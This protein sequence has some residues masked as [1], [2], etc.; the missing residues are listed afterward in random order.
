MISTG[1]V[2]LAEVAPEGAEERPREEL[3]GLIVWP[4][5]VTVEAAP[6]IVRVFEARPGPMTVTASEEVW[7]PAEVRAPAEPIAAK[8]LLAGGAAAPL[9]PP[10]VAL[11]P[12]RTVLLGTAP[13]VPQVGVPQCLA[14]RK[15]SQSPASRATSGGGGSSSRGWR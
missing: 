6:L 15:Q 8:T 1:I 3:S 9:R 11:D 4:A 10:P 5:A 7:S 13:A 12:S 14:E 2:E